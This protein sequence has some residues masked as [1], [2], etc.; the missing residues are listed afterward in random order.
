MEHV[1]VE[2]AEEAHALESATWLEATVF[3]V[4]VLGEEEFTEQQ[5]EKAA[6]LAPHLWSRYLS[7]MPALRDVLADL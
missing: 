4:A 1:V 2:V 7:L 5:Y 6:A 3:F